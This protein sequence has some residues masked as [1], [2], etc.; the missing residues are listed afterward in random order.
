MERPYFN[1][2]FVILYPCNNFFLIMT[3]SDPNQSTAVLILLMY[4][5]RWDYAQLHPDDS[6]VHEIVPC[7]AHAL[8]QTLPTMLCIPLVNNSLAYRKLELLICLH[9][10]MVHRSNRGCVSLSC[11]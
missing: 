3:V 4:V 1:C 6:H 9:F 11:G 10:P 5:A 2:F 8:A 7:S